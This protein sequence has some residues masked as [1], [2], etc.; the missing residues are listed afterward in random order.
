MIKNCSSFYCDSSIILFF[1]LFQGHFQGVCTLFYQYL[2][3]VKVADYSTTDIT[4]KAV[5]DLMVVMEIEILSPLLQ[6]CK[7]D[8]EVLGVLFS[9]YRRTS[10]ARTLMARLPWL[11]RTGA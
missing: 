4:V 10:V 1:L 11:S 3:N 6:L 9:V 7:K 2:L 5:Q 8:K